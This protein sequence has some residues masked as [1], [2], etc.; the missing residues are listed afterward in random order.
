MVRNIPSVTSN[1]S[2]CVTARDVV[3]SAIVIALKKIVIMIDQLKAEV[4]RTNGPGRGWMQ[5][6]EGKVPEFITMFI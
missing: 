5:E 6:T 1:R 3:S 2:G 4:Y